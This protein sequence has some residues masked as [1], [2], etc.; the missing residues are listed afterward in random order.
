MSSL[1]S[2][3]VKFMYLAGLF[4]A[5]HYAL[6]VYIN[7]SFLNQYFSE[8]TVGL[9][10]TG[11]SLVTLLA[12]IASSSI[13]KRIGNVSFVITALLLEITALIGLFRTDNLMLIKVFFIMHLAL[14]P[15]LVFGFDL[16]LE[17]MLHNERKTGRIR[18]LYMTSI[19][20]A[21]VAAPLVTGRIVSMSSYNV[22]YLVSALFCI[23]LFF[24]IVDN[25]RQVKIKKFREVNFY[26]SVKKFAPRR[27]LDRIFVI[28]FLL[29][30][31]YAT[32]VIFAPLYL[33]EYIGFD[34]ETIGLMF[35]VMLLAFVLFEAPLGKMFD[36]S[37]IEKDT[38][39]VG[40]AI[41]SIATISMFFVNTPDVLLWTALLFLSRVGASFVEIAVEYSFFKRVTDQDVGFIS[42]FRMASP[43]AYI[44]VPAI[45]SPLA[46][47]LPLQFMFLIT[48]VAILSGIIFSYKLKTH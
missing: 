6:T 24:I 39:M 47:V 3:K 18:S 1:I 23:L 29:S 10:Y 33:H 31:F 22:L 2:R 32:M 37:H 16:F 7:S 40:F 20:V 38:L 17:E 42:I 26:D 15:L 11:A 36:K 9:L 44:I 28:S 21:F 48:G 27:D 30:S 19:N 8:K 34:W 25:L 46:V 41:M 4:L 5:F 14:S 13:L 12:L 43:L 45:V 35:T